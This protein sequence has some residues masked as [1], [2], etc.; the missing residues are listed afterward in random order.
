[1]ISEMVAAEETGDRLSHGEILSTCLLLLIAGHE[2]TTG[3]ITN[4][5]L[6]LLENR[7]QWETLCA[8]PN[9]LDGAIEE[10]L[11][12]DT[13]VQRMARFAKEETELAGFT[14]KKG[15]TVVAI[16]GAANRDPAVFAD[17]HRL[18]I[19]RNPNPHVSFGKGIHYCLGAPLARLEAEIAFGELARRF[20][21]MRLDPDNPPV[22][23]GNSRFRSLKSLPVRVD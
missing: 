22:S 4:G 16:M 11:R 17:P 20:P 2:T 13:P 21:R 15:E 8:N 6:R 1:M 7:Q 5:M 3:L 14:I 10:L 12:Y 9:L 19:G 23:S 18:D